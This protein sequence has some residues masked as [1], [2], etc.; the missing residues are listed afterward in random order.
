MKC[1]IDTD[2]GIDDAMAIFF[3]LASPELEVLGFLFFFCDILKT[4]RLF[5]LTF[6][7]HWFVLFPGLTIV[8]GNLGDLHRLGT[9]ARIILEAA[10][11][12][13]IPVYLG[14]DKSIV[15]N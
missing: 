14:I 12:P 4:T 5:F 15:R 7:L 2:P 3:A 6:Q 11:R 8:H 9:N 10:G 13:E 1:I